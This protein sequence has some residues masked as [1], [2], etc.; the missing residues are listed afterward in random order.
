VIF[1]ALAAVTGVACGARRQVAPAPPPGPISVA[2][3]VDDLPRHGAQTA[4]RPP[5][6]V[7]AA[8]L[9]AFARHR[10]PKVYGFIN[11]GKLDEHPEDRAVLEAWVAAGHPLANHTFTHADLARVPVA[12]FLDE[13][14]RNEPL[15]AALA[16]SGEGWRLFRY[17][18]LREGGDAATRA[19][20]RTHLLS[21]GYRIAHVTVD[22]YDWAY[23]DPY[24][25][26]LDAASE[27]GRAA[28]RASFLAEAKVKLGW[29]AAAGAT[30]AGRPVRHILLL[31]LGAIDAD[32]IDELLTAYEA[33]NVRWISLDE[34]LDDP[35]YAEAP[36]DSSG[37]AFLQQLFIARGQRPP[38]M[39]RTPRSWQGI[40]CTLAPALGDNIPAPTAGSASDRSRPER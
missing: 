18:Y 11:G 36:R 10:V 31:H 30:L 6:Q 24:V 5:V 29:A 37:G 8:L 33:M 3:T 34:A 15:L 35:L 9:A 23:N 22:P 28:V 38:P 26:C 14:D 39:E 40:A 2:V 27:Q 1:A 16:G 12:A 20:V 19:A 13:I 4:S 21:R 17:P 32:A 25:R 7:A